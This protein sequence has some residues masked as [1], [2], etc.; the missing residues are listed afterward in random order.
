MYYD[1][2]VNKDDQKDTKFSP[3]LGYPNILP[4]CLGMIDDGTK[5]DKIAE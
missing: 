4:L 2:L 3:H 1:L 5:L